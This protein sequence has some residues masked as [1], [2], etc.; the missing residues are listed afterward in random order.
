MDSHERQAPE[1]LRFSGGLESGSRD[2]NGQKILSIIRRLRA[3]GGV[4]ACAAALLSGLPAGA[5]ERGGAASEPVQGVVVRGIEID[6]S[7]RIDAN[8]IR[9]VLVTE[10]GVPVTRARIAEDV[11]RIYD[12]GFFRDIRVSARSVP[13]GQVLTYL[14]VEQPIIRRVTVIGNENL[15]SEDIQD[16]LTLTVG[17][18]ID[19][20]L[21]IEN[22]A[23]IEGLYQ[24]KGLLPRVGRVPDRGAR[25]GLGVGE[26]RDH[27]GREGEVARDRLHGQRVSGR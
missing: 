24:S 21:L 20:P 23:R 16:Q 1:Q 4:L 17:S 6:G 11:R 15:D 2:M 10:L 22:R 9:A 26:L 12:L 7:R 5:Q 25:P 27:R 18:T 3:T 13:G 8:A 14:V 19:Y